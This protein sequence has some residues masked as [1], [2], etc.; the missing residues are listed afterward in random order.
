MIRTMRLRRTSASTDCQGAALWL[1]LWA[2]FM[3]SAALLAWVEFV[4]TD[5]ERAADANRELE[6]KAMAHSAVALALHPLIT[7]KTPPIEEKFNSLMGFRA[8]FVGEGKKLNITWLLTGM[9]PERLDLLKRWLETRG[10]NYE[11]REHFVDCLCDYVDADNVKLLNGAED[12]D[13]YLPAN[14][15]LQSVDE[16]EKVKNAGPLLRSRGW[17]DELTIYSQ[18]PIDISSAEEAV[19]NLIPGLGPARIQRILQVRRGRD[20]IDGTKDD[21]QFKDFKTLGSY[22]GMTSQ[23]QLNELQKFIVLKDQ[24]Q[25]IMAEGYSANVVRQ[26]EVVTRKSGANPAI[27]FWKE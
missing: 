25:R 11:E 16:I 27:L 8:R 22:I 15:P 12:E 17:K 21:M 23:A 2:I 26:V 20:Q 13:D 1:V 7:D 4:Q 14:R 24:T 6:A 9:E 18:G 3:L 5:L 10:L 19:L